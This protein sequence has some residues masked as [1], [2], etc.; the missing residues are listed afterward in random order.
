[1]S[2]EKLKMKNRYIGK[3][4]GEKIYY[5]SEK[6]I[7]L[8]KKFLRLREI[9]DPSKLVKINE[10]EKK[11]RE[12]DGLTKI[13][14]EK[15]RRLGKEEREEFEERSKDNCNYKGFFERYGMS[16]SNPD[17][18]KVRVI[19]YLEMSEKYK[20]ILNSFFRE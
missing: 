8:K 11:A 16:Y 12:W 10:L 7:Y 19:T 14:N 5:N 13:I 17:D 20:P 2:V 9:N 15:I 4:E 18:E 3:I 6:N 1:M